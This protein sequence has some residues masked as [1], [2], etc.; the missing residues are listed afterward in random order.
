MAR[1]AHIE[2]MA[3]LECPPPE[4]G[5]V[6]SRL[7]GQKSDISALKGVHD[8]TRM[9]ISACG[10]YFAFQPYEA[11]IRGLVSHNLS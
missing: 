2:A 9:L 10:C 3:V 7:E 6:I 1:D 8:G 4:V 5:I 11:L